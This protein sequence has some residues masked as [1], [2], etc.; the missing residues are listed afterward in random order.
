MFTQA[1]RHVTV[2]ECEKLKKKWLNSVQATLVTLV[3]NSDT[4]ACCDKST[5]AL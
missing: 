2:G 1:F 5:S 3:V 4:F